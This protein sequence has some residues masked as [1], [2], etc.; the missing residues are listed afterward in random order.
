MATANPPTRHRA[1]DHV[2]ELL[3]GIVDRGQ[4]ALVGLD[5]S[6]G[7]PAGFAAAAGGMPT[8]R[9]TAVLPPW[10][11]T[12][13]L[14][15]SLIEDGADNTNNRFAVAELLNRRSGARLF[16]G[17]PVGPR[18]DGLE[19]LPGRD[20]LPPDLRPNPLER[21]RLTERLAAGGIRSNW[22]LFG[23][24]TVGGQVLMGLPWLAR[25]V[26]RF[27]RV[28]AV[29]PFETG[30]GSPTGSPVGGAERQ[31]WF[32]EMWP[33]RLAGSSP[34]GSVR[35]EW[36]VRTVASGCAR[37]SAADWEAAWAPERLL[38]QRPEALAQVLEEEGWILGV[39]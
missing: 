3:Q 30:L 21:F 29:W 35:D 17:R 16:W 23:A 8:D 1:F 11:R 37:W 18:F 10:R 39:R 32:A 24:G 9:R 33:P 13:D 14:V 25:L 2:A 4:R 7:Y 15:G 34:V 28:A 36:Q 26:E 12:W 20:V 19:R 38:D 27:R 6:F 5:F 22:Q 31:L